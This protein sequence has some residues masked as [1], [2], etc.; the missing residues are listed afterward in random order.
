[1]LSSVQKRKLVVNGDSEAKT[2]VPFLLVKSEPAGAIISRL[3]PNTE[4][5][6]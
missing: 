3:F 6:K 4:V 5:A 2:L 1:M